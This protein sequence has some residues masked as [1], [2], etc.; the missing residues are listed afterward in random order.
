MREEAVP[1]IRLGFRI[2]GPVRLLRIS[3]DD[4]GAV[5]FLIVVA[6]DI[7][8]AGARPGRAAAGALEPVVLVGSVVDD[9]F[10]DDAQ[11]A[12]LGFVDEALEVLHRAEV[13]VDAAVIGDVIAVVAARRRV[14]RHQ[15]QRGD[16]ELL[17]IVQLLGEADEVADAIIVAV[18]EGLHMELVD[19]RVLVPERIDRIV[20]L[21]D[22][23]LGLDVGHHIHGRRF[24]ARQRNRVAGS[25]CGSM[26]RRMPPH[27]TPWRSPVMMFSTAA[28][29]RFSPSTVTCVSMGSQNS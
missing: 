24:Q 18:G 16:A 9:E 5:I 10:G 17:Q 11:A 28:T 26:R 7:P 22:A 20:R 2:P 23:R 27:S 29:L 21:L 1:V 8:V 25:R 4:A 12:A 15:P 3:E 6:P 13:R 19:D 14:E